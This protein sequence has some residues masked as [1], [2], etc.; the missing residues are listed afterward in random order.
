MGQ[1]DISKRLYSSKRAGNKPQGRLT[2]HEVRAER[3]TETPQLAKDEEERGGGAA[4]HMEANE[5]AIFFCSDPPCNC[6]PPLL[7]AE[8][9]ENTFG[10]KRALLRGTEVRKDGIRPTTCPVDHNYKDNMWQVNE[11]Q[12]HRSMSLDLSH[13]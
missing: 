7:T 10:N 2:E 13:R 12:Y 11:V 9:L 3:Q 5:A 8:D 6:S 1:L 4:S